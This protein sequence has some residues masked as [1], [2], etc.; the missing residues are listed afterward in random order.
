MCQLAGRCLLGRCRRGLSR[1][2]LGVLAAETLDAAG[3]IHQ[4]LFAGE[5]RM[6][7]RA[8]FHGNVA[9]VGRT[10]LKNASAS[11]L[12]A[13]FGVVGVNLFL[14]HRSRQTFPANLLF[15]CRGNCLD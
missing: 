11:A 6:A 2:G 8:D 1:V 9:L 5:E 4:T 13:H 7:Y 15:Y 14:G 12:D 10:G 3:R